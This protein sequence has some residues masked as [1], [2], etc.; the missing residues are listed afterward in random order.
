METVVFNVC[1]NIVSSLIACYIY[2]KAKNH[3]DANKSGFKR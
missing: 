1:L 2:D 3:S